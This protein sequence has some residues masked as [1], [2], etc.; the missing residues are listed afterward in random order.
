MWRRDGAVSRGRIRRNYWGPVKPLAYGGTIIMGVGHG[1]YTGRW[2]T[3]MLGRRWGDSTS[4][5]SSRESYHGLSISVSPGQIEKGRTKLQK[6]SPIWYFHWQV[7]KKDWR[8]K[9]T[10]RLRRTS[11][12]RNADII[13]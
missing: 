13:W 5:N 7:R 11:T 12:R 8:S 6:P 2:D 3:A 4:C 1:S 9:M 10:I